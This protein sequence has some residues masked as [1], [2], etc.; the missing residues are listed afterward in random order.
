MIVQTVFPVLNR[1]NFRMAVLVKGVDRLLKKVVNME[2]VI[3]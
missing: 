1:F 2:D 3:N